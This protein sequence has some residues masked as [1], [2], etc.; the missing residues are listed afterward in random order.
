[1]LMLVVFPCSF[2][3]QPTNTA[4]LK[5]MPLLSGLS[6]AHILGFKL[7]YYQKA[8]AQPTPPSLYRLAAVLIAHKWVELDDPYPHLAPEDPAAFAERAAAI[9]VRMEATKRIGAIN[10]AATSL[11][12][13]EK[14][15]DEE[16]PEVVALTDSF[17]NAE[18]K[19]NQ[20]LSLVLG[21]LEAGARGE[22]QGLPERLAP[23]DT[24]DLID[25][26]GGATSSTFGRCRRWRA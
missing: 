10:L 25:M 19:E 4:F 7:Q 20:K 24:A 11:N 1:L 21:L 3:S 22:A 6:I 14:S 17:D 13:D 5:L 15:P 16:A 23:L 26:E 18:Q 2:E 8:A 9:A 12:P